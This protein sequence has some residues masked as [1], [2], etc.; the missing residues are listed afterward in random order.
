M[1]SQ[2]NADNCLNWVGHGELRRTPNLLRQPCVA[3]HTQSVRTQKEC[4]YTHMQ[5]VS[6]DSEDL[7]VYTECMYTHMQ[8]VGCESKDLAITPSVTPGTPTP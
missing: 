4:M 3:L 6:C 7:Y 5:Q 1:I 8:Q 2:K